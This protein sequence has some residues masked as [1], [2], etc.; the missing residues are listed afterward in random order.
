MNVIANI[1]LVPIGAGVSLSKYVAVCE[2]VFKEA[3]LS[4]HL[5]ANGTNV[6]G[7]WDAVF[8]AIKRC[9]EEVH[10]MNVVRIHTSIQLGTRTDRKQKMKDKVESVQANLPADKK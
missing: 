8:G 2:R 1:S 7:E 6:E 4:S 5:H 10:A 3:G 9:H